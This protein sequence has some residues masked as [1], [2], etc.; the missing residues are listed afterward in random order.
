MCTGRSG[1]PWIS[2]FT[3][4]VSSST[5]EPRSPWSARR[6]GNPGVTDVVPVNVA[7]QPPSSS[8]TATA[9]SSTSI[10]RASVRA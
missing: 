9:V 8:A 2:H 1:S 4:R 6:R 5:I 7:R 3:M 10:C